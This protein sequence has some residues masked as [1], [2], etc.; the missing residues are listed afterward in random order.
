MEVMGAA[1]I[2]R[3]TRTACAQWPSISLTT[4]V[5]VLTGSDED[6]TDDAFDADLDSDSD[7]T[8]P[9]MRPYPPLMPA[10]AERLVGGAA[11][12]VDRS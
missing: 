4:V 10:V 6:D 3:R 7:Y 2:G 8:D 12:G 11:A 5:I 1:V 9:L